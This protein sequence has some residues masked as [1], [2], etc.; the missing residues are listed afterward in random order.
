MT[1]LGALA[2]QL[3]NQYS[4]GEN[5]T[6][7]LDAVVN[8]QNQKYGSLGDFAK[9][10]DQSAQRSYLE[11]GYL[12][13]GSSG[14]EPKQFELLMQE[15]N[16]TVLVKK[17]AFSSIGENYNPSYMNSDEKLYFKAMK[18]LFQNKCRQIAVLEKLSKI[19]KI[20]SGVGSVSDQLLPIIISLT[21]TL[22][23]NSSDNLP[24]SFFGSPNSNGDVSSFTQVVERL[25]RIYAFNTT[26]DI[27]TWITDSSNLF[28]SQF[29]QGTGVIEITNFTSLS[30]TCT[31]S[32]QS[33]GGFN[34]T[35]S[36]PYE[37][38]LI[39]EWDIEKAISDATNAF[40]NS[41]IY[42]F[43][44][45][46][47]AQVL[48]DAKSR[49]N[50]LRS[51]R[52]ASPIEFIVAPNTVIN[53]RVRAIIDASGTEILF[54]YNSGF[55]GLNSSVIVAPEYL[56]GGAVAGFNGL[57]TSVN[58]IAGLGPDNNI[59]PLSP[60]SELAIFQQIITT[61]FNQLTLT[62]NSQSAFQT[63][64]KNTNYARA[65]LRFQ[66]SGKVLIQPMDTVHIYINSKSRYDDRLL[67]GLQNM[68]SGVGILQNLNNTLTG[69]TNAATTL[70]N[71][72]GNIQLQAE[73][74][75][76]V[77]ANFPNYLWSLLRNQ[78]V[79]EKE[80]THIAAGVVESAPSNW[81]DG[82]F[83]VDVRGADN[84]FYFGLGK[85]NW[86]PGVDV[87]NGALF[88]PLTPFKTTFDTITSNAKS[89]TPELLDENK[90]LLGTSEDTTSPLVKFK[91]G[92]NMGLPAHADN[93]N[94]D[95]TIDNVTGQ[96]GKVFYAPDG[97]VYKW[98][99]GIG[100]LVQFGDS[101]D[102][103]DPNK[104]GSPALTKEPFAG[105]DVMNVISL[106]VT[107]QPY[108]FESY[109]RAVS[110]FDGASRDPQS[111]Q[112]AAYSYYASLQTD[113][114]KNNATWGNFI[115]FKSLTMDEASFAKSVQ[116][117]IRANRAD[118]E[119][120]SLVKQLAT[121]QNQIN[122]FSNAVILNP[123]NT[124]KYNNDKQTA[125]TTLT[126]LTQQINA[127]IAL[128]QKQDQSSSQAISTVGD[129]SFQPG[130]FGTGTSQAQTLSDAA[131]R[132]SLRRQINYLTRRMSYNVRANEDK[133]L[134]IVDDSYDKDYDITAYEESLE[135][136]IK[137]YNNEFSSVKDKIISTA[138]LLNL[139]VFADT[140]GHIRVRSPQYNRMPSSV[141]YRMLYL[142]K[143]YG[144]QIY[145]Q[146]LE[147]LFGNQINTLTQKVEVLENQIRLNCAVLGIN[148]DK[149]CVS[150]I[151]QGATTAGAADNFGF[152]S[153]EGVAPNY[154]F[155]ITDMSSVLEAANPDSTNQIATSL[156]DQ[157]G[158][159]KQSFNNTQKYQ[160][161]ISALTGQ[162]LTQAGYGIQDV[163]ALATNQRLDAII[164][165][166]KTDTGQ[167]ISK[168][169]YIVSNDII[170]NSVNIPAGQTIDVF[171]VTSDL[172]TNLK[173]RQ[174]A[175][176]LLYGAVKNSQEARSLDDNS[177]TGNDLLT[178]GVYGN[179]NTPEVFEHM[180]E[181]E[182]YDDYGVDSGSRYI[183]KRA[184][185]RN[186]SITETA[187]DFTYIEVRGQID[188]LLANTVLPGD[189]NSF[190][191]SGN[192]LVTAAAVDYDLWRKYGHRQQSPINVPFLSDPNTQCAPYASMILSR[193]RQNILRG[194]ITISGNEFM[195]PGEVV[196]LQDRQMLFYV[197][198]VR[199][200]FTFGQTF[201]TTLDL[202][203]GHTP[204]EY[205]PTTLDVIGKMLY[206]N[207]DLANITIQ[208][209]SSPN[210]D[211]NI[212]VVIKDPTGSTVINK[213]TDGSS[214]TNQYTAS[215]GKVINNIL[216]QAAYMI[217]ANQSKGNTI[218]AVV[219][220][221]IYYDNNN[222]IDSGLQTFA[223]SIKGF[224]T[225][226]NNG[227]T[228]PYNSTTSTGGQNPY[229]PS[230]NV[231]VV[232]VNM[233]DTT[234]ANS[235]SQK[236]IDMARNMI[237]Q[238]SI[239]G[240][241][242]SQPT[243]TSSGGIPVN[244]G[245]ANPLPSSGQSPQDQIRINLFT[246]VVDCWLSF[247][248]VPT[249]V[250]QGT[251]ANAQ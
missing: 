109:W 124:S 40:Y 181:D 122:L 182:T 11:E 44:Q 93:I 166:L 24:S 25:R 110:N 118:N 42:Q 191:Q 94:N 37:T 145:P 210:N 33:P 205:I 141:F 152:I 100:T 126:Q 80:G 229:L 68:F 19:Q 72:S 15:P 114:I 224:L 225:N 161:V 43:G 65:K 92:P 249:N 162:Q 186:I 251:N 217:N 4:L 194:S 123:D 138:D 96:A 192:G 29:G 227:I 131:E 226:P 209:Q 8:G 47:A 7:S 17:A 157:A 215:N 83:T 73:K 36:D 218:N 51:A 248:Q 216:Y 45:D 184:Q 173:N 188:P 82:R 239:S 220:L 231:N 179:S 199:H 132:R 27:T 137:L 20:T 46:S 10:I 111:Q 175:L 99:E 160:A 246:Y 3:N 244:S 158:T 53:K 139:E 121:V 159:K 78:F 170:G 228:Q 202:T 168:D 108:N 233:D 62:A 240:G 230:S 156:A 9:N 49:F 120:D 38:M 13:L 172:S 101:T 236:A 201:T 207:R 6:T 70:F 241:G 203:Y 23:S 223:N 176:K 211:S 35:I 197:T 87:F 185:I 115:P 142:K 14:A 149:D 136:G 52:N 58:P 98:K 26:N 117:V 102:I 135:N 77:G 89:Q 90:Y 95:Y 234:T 143:A 21:D 39:T 146:F 208:R 116:G 165:I 28:Q 180:I 171:K 163:P 64:N 150:F 16:A 12:R 63:S 85:V 134:F 190:P 69:L 177:N 164:Q 193:A 235:P 74:S 57:S 97:L 61:T 88:D 167:Q 113:L 219:E 112:D 55:A 32:I 174:K 22:N 67:D 243:L 221:R 155:R 232:L 189:L 128:L 75:S 41:K 129:P 195:Q 86:K 5:T 154:S 183:I 222:S 133:N 238:N 204:G 147:D 103:N 76:F 200:N 1:F 81:S 79:T 104:V 198:S 59:Q 127:K 214:Y 2:N 105:Q 34:F 212:G 178:P 213:G 54:T 237:T 50:Q 106:L 18:V 84:T 247:E 48:N 245:V 196:F 60:Q 119:L 56:Q 31:N 30:T 148:T 71:P 144:V 250:A 151:T 66:F 140:Q 125:E 130:T 169:S 187:P 91:L 242:A 107:G 206:S 153:N